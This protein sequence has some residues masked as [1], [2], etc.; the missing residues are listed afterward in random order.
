MRGTSTSTAPPASNKAAAVSWMRRISWE[1]AYARV[2]ATMRTDGGMAPS[3]VRE[4][5]ADRT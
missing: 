2:E 4:L 3:Q 1:S 5:N